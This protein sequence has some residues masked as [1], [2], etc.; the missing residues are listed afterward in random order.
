MLLENLKNNK[1]MNLRKYSAKCLQETRIIKFLHIYLPT[2]FPILEKKF[3]NAFFKYFQR[4]NTYS[5]ETTSNILS[6][7]MKKYI[8][9]H[10]KTLWALLSR[11]SWPIF[12]YL[13]LLTCSLC[14][15]AL[16]EFWV[17]I[18]LTSENYF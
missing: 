8:H 1:I 9:K 17:C 3:L 11:R 15:L 18:I 6:N 5:Q 13:A 14:D 4:L 12:E 2:H 10:F 16:Q 7:E